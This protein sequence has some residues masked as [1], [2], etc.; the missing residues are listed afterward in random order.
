MK[1]RTVVEGWKL[2][3]VEGAIDL[4]KTPFNRSVSPLRATAGAAARGAKLKWNARRRFLRHGAE[5]F[6][7]TQRLTIGGKRHERARSR[8]A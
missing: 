1:D 5:R 3:T 4:N 6:R 2:K 7:G 8:K